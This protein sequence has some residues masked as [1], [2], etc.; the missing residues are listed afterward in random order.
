[1]CIVYILKIQGFEV[2]FQEGEG[3]GAGVYLECY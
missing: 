1:M 2:K 3:G